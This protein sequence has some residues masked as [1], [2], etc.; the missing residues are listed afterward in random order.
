MEESIR[1]YFSAPLWTEQEARGQN[2]LVL[3]YIGDAVFEIFVRSVILHRRQKVSRL[4]RAS[5]EKV[6]ASSQAALA[7]ALGDFFTEEEEA[8]FKRG[9]NTHQKTMAK[10]AEVID[11]R[12]ATGFECLIGYLYGAGKEERLREYFTEIERIWAN[13]G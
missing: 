8:I 4:H 9:R 3:A 13:E 12:N 6:K 11:Y 7:L 2:P 1:A 5:A 10:H